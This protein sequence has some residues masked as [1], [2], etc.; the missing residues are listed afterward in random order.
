[1]KKRHS[2][3]QIVGKLRQAD[4]ALGK[5]LKVPEVCRELG[6]SE[7]TYYRWRQKY[8]GRAPEVAKQLK[9]LEKENAMLHEIWMADTRKDALKAFDLFIETFRAKYPKA[10]ECLEKD[11]DVLL[12][13]YDFPAEHWVHLRTTN[14]IEST[15][16]TAR[17]RTRRT[18]G[19]GSRIACLTMVWKLVQSAAKRWRAL[20][21]CEIIADVIK[22]VRFVD[23]VKELAA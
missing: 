19:S 11:R 18:K 22:G 21:G 12:T 1:M 10:V 23:G 6:I 13:F 3:Q 15:F 20:N 17:L 8:G 7:Q 5:G 4:V 14:P 2:A 16:A 9:A